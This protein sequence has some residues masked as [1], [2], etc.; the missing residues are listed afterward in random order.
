MDKSILKYAYGIV[1]KDNRDKEAKEFVKKICGSKDVDIK[2][3]G[4]FD[5]FVLKVFFIDQKNEVNIWEKLIEQGYNFDILIVEDNDG[6][7]LDYVFNEE[8]IEK[9]NDEDS[10]DGRDLIFNEEYT[11]LTEEA[12]NN[13]VR[14]WT[15]EKVNNSEEYYFINKSDNDCPLMVLVGIPA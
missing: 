13:L 3:S 5:P 8:F 2:I 12:K 1:V 14:G 9:V 10:F 15:F 4:Y 7:S 6:S 11:E